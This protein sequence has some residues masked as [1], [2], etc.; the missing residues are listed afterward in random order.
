MRPATYQLVVYPTER[1]Q[2]AGKVLLR[3]AESAG[4]G[5]EEQ[6]L[7]KL[8]LSCEPDDAIGDLQ[9]ARQ[10]RSATIPATTSTSSPRRTM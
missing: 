9:D 1:P 7:A 3:R 4:Q 5:F 2:A 8:D 10:R 6:P